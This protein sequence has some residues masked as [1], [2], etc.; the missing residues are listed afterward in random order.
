MPKRN[1]P[2]AFAFV[3]IDP[4]KQGGIV[5]INYNGT[6][7]RWW[8]M[9]RGDLELLTLLREL[10]AADHTVVGIEAVRSMPG[11]GHKGAFTFGEGYGGLK[12]AVAACGYKRVDVQPRTWQKYFKIKT[13]GKTPKNE[14]KDGIR[15]LAHQTFPSVKLWAQPKTLGKQRAI[16]DAMFIAEYTRLTHK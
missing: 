13:R 14:F 15:L 5:Y 3:G 1:L 9:P 2:D 10:P 8:L 4:G 6:D 11:E 12:M 16:C 7:I